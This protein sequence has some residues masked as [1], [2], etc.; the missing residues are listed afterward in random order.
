MARVK[1]ASLMATASVILWIFIIRP[2][3]PVSFL[4]VFVRLIPALSLPFASVSQTNA[5]PADG[6]QSIPSVFQSG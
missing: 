1:R 2:T 6:H 4:S 5:P 3:K